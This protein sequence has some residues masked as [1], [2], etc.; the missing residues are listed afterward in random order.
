MTREPK[1]LK[2]K[3]AKFSMNGFET[4]RY[5]HVD[6]YLTPL[7]K[8]NSKWIKDLHIRLE[9]MKFIEEN[10]VDNLLDTHFGI[11][12]LDMTPKAQAKI[13]KLLY[14]LILFVGLHQIKKSFHSKINN[15]EYKEATNIL[16][17]NICTPYIR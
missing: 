10:I 12:F 8:I 11:S 7:I 9:T 16:G 13:N 14:Y 17:E 3:K 15:Q 1:I 5:S 6:A 4:N 2:D